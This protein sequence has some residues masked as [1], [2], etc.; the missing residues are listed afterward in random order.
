MRID[1][2]LVPAGARRWA[3]PSAS[4]L[5]STIAPVLAP[6]RPPHIGRL[7]A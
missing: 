6:G 5:T 2:A 4:S 7:E 1:L 3:A